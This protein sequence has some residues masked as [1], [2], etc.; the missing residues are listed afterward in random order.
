MGAGEASIL[1][2]IKNHLR[3]IFKT[4]AEGLKGEHMKKKD[5]LML[6]LIGVLIAA[7][8]GVILYSCTR[9]AETA[10]ADLPVAS[11][12]PTR[13]PRE[14]KVVV[15]ELDVRMIEDGLHDMGFL[16]T[17]KYWFKEVVDYKKIEKFLIVINSESSYLASY[18]GYVTAG[19]SFAD[20]QVE[21]DEAAKTVTVRLPEAEIETVYIDHDSM[22]KYSEKNGIFSQLTIDD[23]NDGLKGL[24]ETAEK[25]AV[26]RGLLVNAH[27]N[28]VL[29]VRN[30]VIGLLDGEDYTLIVE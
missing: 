30:F 12:R 22:V 17:Q 27:E 24:E 23:F 8:A 16:T 14:P 19:I 20:I 28:A 7:C 9:P 18:E 21:K 3:I 25:N 4:L 10:S 11:A 1:K 26:E 29:L 5:K 13:E 15:K 6:G 2:S